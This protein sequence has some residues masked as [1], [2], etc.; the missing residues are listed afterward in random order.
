LECGLAG[1]RTVRQS[2]ALVRTRA[3]TGSCAS[4]IGHVIGPRARDA[5]AAFD[6]IANAASGAAI[7][8]AA[9]V[10]SG[11]TFDLTANAASG[12]PIDDT[13]A[14]DV[15]ASAARDAIDVANDYAS[16]QPVHSATRRPRDSVYAAAGWPCDALDI[17]LD[18]ALA[19]DAVDTAADC[20]RG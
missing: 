14:I 13:A 5:I 11:A 19:R 8:T 2:T 10:A 9:S 6:L 15:A 7:D 20:A 18:I 4:S 1:K 17:A 16:G 3:H 12:P